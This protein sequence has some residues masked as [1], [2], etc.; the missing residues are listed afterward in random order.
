VAV[1]YLISLHIQIC[2]QEL[3]C[4]H[5]FASSPF[6][7]LV[8]SS[9]LICLLQLQAALAAKRGQDSLQ[10]AF[11]VLGGAAGTQHK[12]TPFQVL[13]FFFIFFYYYFFLLFIYFLVLL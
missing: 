2:F 4:T 5:L 10:K 6:F 1:L 9:L 7:F 12:T 3:A 8:F 11:A 13:F